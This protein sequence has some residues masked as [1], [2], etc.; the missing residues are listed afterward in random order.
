MGRELDS[1]WCEGAIGN[2]MMREW[3]HQM[4]GHRPLGR[5]G[6]EI[7]MTSSGVLTSLK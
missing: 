5:K 2:R 6:R 1:M 3:P 4:T 7:Y